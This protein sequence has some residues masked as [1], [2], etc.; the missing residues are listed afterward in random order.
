MLIYIILSLAIFL[1]ITFFAL[2]KRKKLETL[3][4]KLTL[5][6]SISAAI[7]SYPYFHNELN[8]LL[9]VFS[10]IRY[11]ADIIT[12]DVAKEV[13]DSMS[14]IGPLFIVYK[15]LMYTY[16]ILAPIFASIAVLSFSKAFIDGIRIRMKGDI[17]LFSSLNEK[18]I[19]VA[20]Y[21]RSKDKYAKI[22]FFKWESADQKVSFR[23]KDI[24]S[25]FPKYSFSKFKFRENR[26]YSFYQ[27][28]ESSDS[29]LSNFIKNYQLISKL[30]QDI[31]GNV[32]LKCFT[33]SSSAEMVKKIDKYLSDKKSEGSKVRLS[34]INEENMLSYKLFHDLI[35][36]IST[37]TLKNEFMIIGAGDEGISILKTALW[38]FDKQHMSVSIDVIDKDA[39]SIASKLKLDCP[40]L[41]NAPL[42]QYIYDPGREQAS[43]DPS[44]GITGVLRR[45]THHET[46]GQ[47][48][49]SRNYDI[50]FFEADANSYDLEN[51]LMDQDIDPDLI[52]VTL[53]DDIQCQKTGEKLRRIIAR[54]TN[55][56]SCCPI[57]MRIRND[58]T[59]EVLKHTNHNANIIYFGNNKNRYANIFEMNN[60][61]EDMSR[62]VHLAYMNSDDKDLQKVLN[63]SGY[64]YLSNHESSLAQALSIEYKVK[65]ILKQTK[66]DEGSPR[67]RIKKY[68]SDQMNLT[69]MCMMEHN[70][71]NCFER[72]EGWTTPTIQQEKLIANI[73]GNGKTIN[74]RDL[75]LHPAIVEVKDLSAAE[76]QADEILRNVKEEY[77]P[78]DYVNKDAYIIVRIPSI[79]SDEVLDH[80]STTMNMV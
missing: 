49:F 2:R 79:I 76:K 35:S 73:A 21:I 1:T 80:V 71:W 63:E 30:D 58:K 32:D 34:F 42:D 37:D 46:D 20:E 24:E 55:T 60:M 7:L 8:P 16:Y 18:S 9:S 12:M 44:T 3:S 78:T 68:L 29:N 38:L 70:R 74:D 5:A 11:G 31:I 48:I 17:H 22:I 27:I 4:L 59:Y 52:F 57:A 25:I 51:I 36:V 61:L 65:Y 62:K 28:D 56:L 14:S 54:K 64:Y 19:G 66:Y 13:I 53:S 77:T 10:A 50:R 41:L 6:V 39:V 72:C 26:N 23:A 43:N 40:D 69:N 33:D 47:S 67:E 15:V 75:L 45:I